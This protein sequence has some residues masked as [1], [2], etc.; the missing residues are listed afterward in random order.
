VVKLSKGR[1]LKV[2]RAAM[3]KTLEQLSIT[4]GVSIGMLSLL[5]CGKRFCSKDNAPKLAKAYGVRISDIP[6]KK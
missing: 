5:E 2:K 3:G 1:K 6:T 4:A